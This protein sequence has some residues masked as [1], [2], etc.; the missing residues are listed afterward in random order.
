MPDPVLY[1]TVFLWSLC[2]ITQ[3]FSDPCVLYIFYMRNMH[4]E[5]RNMTLQKLHFYYTTWTMSHPINHDSQMIQLHITLRVDGNVCSLAY[6]AMQNF[7]PCALR[8]RSTIIQHM[9]IW[10][11]LQRWL[12]TISTTPWMF[13][14]EMYSTPS[15]SYSHNYS[16]ID[17]SALIMA[18]MPS[19]QHI[20]RNRI[21]VDQPLLRT[22]CGTPSCK[23]RIGLLASTL[24][25]YY[26]ALQLHKLDK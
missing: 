14:R 13:R 25:Q 19:I 23:S 8:T 24:S 11:C 22:S 21:V 5:K 7:P 15:T 2:Y 26:E 4:I 17:H 6:S 1:N 18:S 16:R 9:Y 10:D 20:P 12:Q 3:Y